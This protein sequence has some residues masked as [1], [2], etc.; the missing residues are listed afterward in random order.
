MTRTAAV[1]PG[2]RNLP[3]PAGKQNIA[4]LR[5]LSDEWRG[6]NRELGS[7]TE[8]RKAHESARATSMRSR[9]SCDAR[10]ANR[11]LGSRRSWRR[12]CGGR[13]GG[14]RGGLRRGDGAAAVAAMEMEGEP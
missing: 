9:S 14:G 11:N 6:T 8:A 7:G 1:A 3:L 4:E 10:A 5:Y 2:R 13:E 12:G